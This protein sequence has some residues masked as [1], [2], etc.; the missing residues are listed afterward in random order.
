MVDEETESDWIVPSEIFYAVPVNAA[1][2]AR[3]VQNDPNK[4]PHWHIPEFAEMFE[5]VRI[6][7]RARK[8]AIPRETAS[9]EGIPY[10]EISS[11]VVVGATTALEMERDGAFADVP[12]YNEDVRHQLLQFCGL[13]RV[14]IGYMD[15]H[16]HLPQRYI[17]RLFEHIKQM[18]MK[19]LPGE[20]ERRADMSDLENIYGQIGISHMSRFG[21]IEKI[22]AVKY[23]QVTETQMERT[24]G[25]LAVLHAFYLGQITSLPSFDVDTAHAVSV[26]TKLI[27]PQDRW[28][29]PL[30]DRLT[31]NNGLQIGIGNF[32]RA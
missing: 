2:L 26:V 16:A 12:L 31:P 9:N 3:A 8:R 1:I 29:T 28:T 14:V 17:N 4:Q 30:V 6:L 21:S 25:A 20:N 23:P 11:E 32:I 27:V 13:T 22:F 7:G 10:T 5:S 18:R 24:V 19:E 15:V